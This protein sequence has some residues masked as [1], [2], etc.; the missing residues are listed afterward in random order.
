[1]QLAG[2]DDSHFS[3]KDQGIALIIA[4]P[5]TAAALHEAEGIDIVMGM[6]GKPVQAVSNF[7]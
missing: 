1:M 3:W 2:V 5:V 4:V 6:V 7:T